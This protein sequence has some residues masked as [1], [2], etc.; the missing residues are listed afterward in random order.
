MWTEG[1]KSIIEQLRLQMSKEPGYDDFLES[2][3]KQL[4][5]REQLTHYAYIMKRLE[6]HTR[7]GSDAKKVF[8][9]SS[10]SLASCSLCL[11]VDACDGRF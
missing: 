6:E 2:R 5:I 3:S 4:T 11:V 8:I 10:S 7:G 9:G 1:D